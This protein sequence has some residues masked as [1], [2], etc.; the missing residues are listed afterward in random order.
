[1]SSLKE[2]HEAYIAKVR[3]GGSK[4]AFYSTPCCRKEL[5]DRLGEKGRVWDTLAVCPYCGTVYLKVITAT[6]IR[7]LILPG[8]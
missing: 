5:E 7:G 2:K 4:T 8:R 1:M 3:A 6:R